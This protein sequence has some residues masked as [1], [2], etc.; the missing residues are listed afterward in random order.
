MTKGLRRKG[1]IKNCCRKLQATKIL[2]RT[3]CNISL[4]LVIKKKQKQ[5][6]LWLRYDHYKCVL[7][8]NISL[9]TLSNNIKSHSKLR[10]GEFVSTTN[11]SNSIFFFIPL[12]T[13]YLA[14]LSLQ[15]F[16]SC[17]CKPYCRCDGT[18]GRTWDVRI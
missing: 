5:E 16:F 8:L 9:I 1:L 6:S 17:Q 2:K 18:D 12:V 10:S 14:L 7:S 4:R 13:Y 15:Q 11:I 3:L